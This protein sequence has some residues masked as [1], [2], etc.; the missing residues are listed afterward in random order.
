[1]GTLPLTESGVREAPPAHAGPDRP[2]ATE[3]LRSILDNS[4]LLIGAQ[5]I[6]SVLAMVLTVLVSRALGD[7]EFGRF[8]LALSL[9]T[10]LGVAVDWGLSQVL[11][12]SVARQRGLARPYLRRVLA[13]VGGL[14]ALLYATALVSAQALGYPADVRDLVLILGVLMVAEAVAQVL[15]AVFQAHERMVVPAVARIVANALML[16]L[17]VVVLRAGYGA[18]MVAA[19]LLVSTLVRVAMQ[20]WAVPRLAGFRTP[21][22][23]TPAWRGLLAA[24]FPFFL[25]NGIGPF[26]FRINVLMLGA[27]TTDAAVGWFGVANRLMDALNF[28]PQFLTM[29]TFPVAARL[30]LTSRADFRATV[31]QTLHLLLVVTVP[32]AVMIHVLAEEIVALLFTLEAYGPAVPILRIHAASLALIFVDFYLVGLLMAIGRER[33]WIAIS[34]SAWCVVGPALNWLLIPLADARWGNGGIGA[35]IATLVTEAGILLVVVRSLPAGTFG[36]EQARV[37][38]RAAALGAGLAA[39]LIAGRAA[40]VPWLLTAALGGAGY[41][42]AAV[43]LGLV[44]RDVLRWIRGLVPRRGDR[45]A[46]RRAA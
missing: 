42:A 12:R 17:V 18:R 43:A 33:R 46:L 22:A 32:A 27:M 30:W 13:L 37:A 16:G 31:R 14:G 21:V 36:R 23:A 7:A 9:T 24:G 6:A 3:P 4:S 28:V 34:I 38:A 41:L 8:H 29:A 45:S 2:A 39:L 35:A 26:F 20:G 44:P 5:V 25:A 1:M 40:G 19:V 11:A 10:I 15:T